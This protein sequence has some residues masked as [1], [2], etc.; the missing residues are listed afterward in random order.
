MHAYATYD[1]VEMPFQTPASSQSSAV[2]VV[3]VIGSSDDTSCLLAGL[4]DLR[5]IIGA[6]RTKSMLELSE[7]AETIVKRAS[8]LHGDPPDVENWAR[9]LA[10]DVGGLCD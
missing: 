8:E 1:D 10:R 4:R 6:F 9:R 5:G 7:S 3:S 2:T